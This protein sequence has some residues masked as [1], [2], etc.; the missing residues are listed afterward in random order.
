MSFYRNWV[1]YQAGFGV[2]SGEHWLGN[3]KLHTITSLKNY[4]LRVDLVDSGGSSYHALYDRFRISNEADKYRL[5]LGSYSGNAG[6][7]S[8]K[9]K[10]FN[11]S[12]S[13]L[14]YH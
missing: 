10:T 7:L 13:A 8:T 3:D 11:I 1:T 4:Q 2:P 5:T 6:L 12:T 14:S 9:Y